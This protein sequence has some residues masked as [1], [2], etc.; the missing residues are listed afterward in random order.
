MPY[1]LSLQTYCKPEFFELA[2]EAWERRLREISP[3][4]PHLAH[5]RFRKF[6]ARA[7]WKESPFNDR[8][9]QPMW[10]VYA[11]TPA[12]LVRPE[13]AEQFRLHWSELP[14]ELQEGRKGVV[15][16][17]QHYM[18]H[19]FRVEARPLW[20]LQGEWGGTPTLYSPREK[21]YLDASGAVSEPFPPGYFRPCPFDERAVK[22]LLARDRLVQAC[23]KYDE[24]EK[25]D[26]PEAL[27]AEDVAGERVFRETYLDTL[28][29]LMAP[30]VEF[31]KSNI[32]KTE[33]NEALPPA[34]KGL[35]NTLAQWK[36]VW[37]EKGQMLGVQKAPMR[38]VHATS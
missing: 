15:S 1:Q 21:R 36:E 8:P 12:A 9:E 24:L 32:G 35:E 7:D 6:E 25:M 29:V 37:V 23:N 20:L 17:Y 22:G 27:R 34:P 31:M 38:R 26:R 14:K 30:A 11:C 5:L 18:W 28:S 16:N 19:A 33:V 4:T 3:I 10:A 2:P 13:R